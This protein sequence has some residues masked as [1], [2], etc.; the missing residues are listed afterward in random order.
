MDE[1]DK[2][3]DIESFLVATIA[4]WL[5]KMTPKECECLAAKHFSYE[6]L[7]KYGVEK[8]NESK[9]AK[10][11]KNNDGL[12]NILASRVVTAVNVLKNHEKCP[13]FI[14]P[15]EQVEL[16]PGMPIT[17]DLSVSESTVSSRLDSLEKNHD[18]V[19]K[20]L[21]EI[22]KSLSFKTAVPNVGQSDMTQV[23]APSVHLFPPHL[24][25]AG[26]GSGLLKPSSTELRTRTFS[27]SSLRSTGSKRSRHEAEVDEDKDT[28]ANVA[29]KRPKPKVNQGKSKVTIAGS[30]N[31]ILPFEAYI[32][33][34]H[35]KSKPEIIEKYLRECFD[36]APSDI[37][38]EG[39]FEVIKIECCTKP[40]DDGKEPWCL[41]WRVTIDQKFRDYILN[42]DAIPVGWTSRRYYPPRAKRPPAADLHPAKVPNTR[43]TA[44]LQTAASLGEQTLPV[45]GDNNFNQ[46]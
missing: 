23:S 37:K 26:S 36:N 41:N 28:Y 6:I 27:N 9:L 30:D 22:R 5:G 39:S 33:N 21:D 35:P 38:P 11:A 8:I 34:T 31:A 3:P 14:I 17:G 42:P 29:G 40:R 32:G 12:N 19:M 43:Q 45:A 4:M 46:Q 7:T 18:V 24:G 10:V 44:L 2:P 15:L 13:R 16:L 25:T 20:A 1:P